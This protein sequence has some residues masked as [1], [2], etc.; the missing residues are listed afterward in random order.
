[1]PGFDSVLSARE[2]DDTIVLIETVMPAPLAT[3]S[4]LALPPQPADP[5]PDRARGAALWSQLG[6]ASCHGLHGA[7]DGPAAAAMAAP[8]FDLTAQPLRRP[9]DPAARSEIAVALDIWTGIGGTAMPGYAGAIG[10]ADLWALA[11]YVAALGPRESPAHALGSLEDVA[12]AADRRAPIA[13]GTRPAGGDLDEDALFTTAIPLQGAPPS[14]LAPATASLGARQC[15][16]CH[17]KQVREW[18]G[19][20]HGAAASPGLRAQIDV[21][22]ERA[23]AACRHCHTPLAE[24]QPAAGGAYDPDLQAEGVTCAGCHVRAWARRGPPNLAPSLLTLPGYPLQ[25]LAIYERGDLCMTCH[26]LPPRTAVAGKPLLNTYAE[27]LDGPYM[28]RG[29]QCQ[30]C[31]MPNREHTVLGIH[32]RDTFRQGIALT[33]SARRAAHGVI[34]ASAILRNIGAGHDLPTTPTPAVWLAI[35][36]VDARGTPLP[37]TRVG[38]RI[39]RDLAF[40]DGAWQERSDTRIAPGDSAILVDGWSGARAAGAV[41]ARFTVTVRPDDYYERFYAQR[42]AAQ[43]PPAAPQRAQYEQALARARASSYVAEDRRV[44]L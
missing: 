29:V 6:C 19:S 28:R 30:H 27:W 34:G 24:Q 37:N 9:R 44:P 11:S 26:Q 32:D 18:T 43:P 8:P 15:G 3:T 42:L 23:A 1:M 21:M 20:L 4:T 5:A 12:I 16:R 7:G 38:K 25:T 33:T 36:L 22:S 10:D 41:A 39:G 14:S 17:A 2:I 40:A 13:V 35:E 31:H